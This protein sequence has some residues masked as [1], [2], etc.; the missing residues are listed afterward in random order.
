MVPG[1]L[2]ALVL[3][4]ALVAPSVGCR[5]TGAAGGGRSAVAGRVFSSGCPAE[6]QGQKQ[7]GSW[8]AGTVRILRVSGC[9][10]P[11]VTCQSTKVVATA[12]SG[13]TGRFQVSLPPGR[14]AVEAVGLFNKLAGQTF[15]VQAGT[16]GEVRVSIDNGIE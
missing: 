13:R 14:Y 16:P 11:V 7:C 6:R 10:T 8:F 12:L 2:I 5:Q 4:A 3:V 15:T 1:H 9:T